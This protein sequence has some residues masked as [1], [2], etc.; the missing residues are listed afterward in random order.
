MTETLDLPL[1]FDPLFFDSLHTLILNAIKRTREL[2]STSGKEIE[3]EVRLGIPK[4]LDREHNRW[5][6]D[7]TIEK[8]RFNRLKSDLDVQ[9]TPKKAISTVVIRELK[10]TPQNRGINTN[11]RKITTLGSDVSTETTTVYQVKNKIESIDQLFLSSPISTPTPTSRNVY[12]LRFALSEEDSNTEGKDGSIEGKF[13]A[14][15]EK[16]TVTRQRERYT[17]SFPGYV[18]DLTIVDYKE[19]SIE[20]EF[21]KEF[22]L[23][24]ENSKLNDKRYIF[25]NR[26]LPPIKS[27]LKLI[28]PTLKDVWGLHDVT[29]RYFNL[30]QIGTNGARLSDVRPQN[31]EE[32]QV[33]DLLTGYSFSN[34]LNGTPYRVMISNFKH[35]KTD[36]CMVFLI[37]N[38]DIKFVGVDV[39][40]RTLRSSISRDSKFLIDFNNSLIDIELYP[41]KGEIQQLH[42]FDCPVFQGK[43]NTIESHDKRLSILKTSDKS[44]SLRFDEGFNLLL[45]SIGYSF[46]IKKFFYTGD[47]LKDLTDVVQYMYN[48]YGDDTEEVNDGI[49]QQPVGTYE[50]VIRGKQV[51]QKKS[52]YDRTYRI[53]KWKFPDTVSIDFV[54]GE[55]DIFTKNKYKNKAFPILGADRDKLI[56]FSPYFR[57]K[58]Y[59]PPSVF[60]VNDQD[61]NYDILESGQVVELGFDDLHNS[62]RLLRVRHDKTEPNAISPTAQSTFTQMESKFTLDKL[63]DLLVQAIER[64]SNITLPKKNTQQAPTSR[65]N[66]PQSNVTLPSPMPTTSNVKCLDSYR[67]L[68]NRIKTGLIKMYCEGKQIIDFGA[69]KGGDLSKIA[70]SDIKY[71]WAVEPNREYINGKDG[72]ID[73]LKKYK[74]NFQKKVE[75]ILTGAEDTKAITQAMMK[76]KDDSKVPES[77]AQVAFSFF[78]ASFFFRDQQTINSIIRSIVGSLQVGGKL[79]GTMMDGQRVYDALQA[80]G[81]TVTDPNKCYYIKQKFPLNIPLT[82]VGSEIGINLSDTPTVQNEQTEWLAPFEYLCSELLKENM[83]LVDTLYFDDPHISNLFPRPRES[84]PTTEDIYKTMSVGEKKLNRLYR[85]FVFERSKPIVSDAS[86]QRDVA[87]QKER[88]KNSLETMD[89]DKIGTGQFVQASLYSEPLY[90]VGVAGMG[91]CFFHAILFSLIS[92]KYS[93]MSSAERIQQAATLR[94]AIAKALSPEMLSILGNGAIEYSQYLPYLKRVLQNDMITQLTEEGGTP[95]ISMDQIN[96][97]MAQVEPL[98]TIQQQISHIISAFGNLGYSQHDIEDII[99]EAR[100]QLWKDYTAK[101]KNCNEWTTHDT[102]EYIMRKLQRNIFIIGDSTRLP[103]KFTDCA[104][105]NPSYPSIVILNLEGLTGKSAEHFEPIIDMI[106]DGDDIITTTNFKW[107][108]SLIKALYSYLCAQKD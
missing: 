48:C 86:K 55:P 98:S 5:Q 102:M 103:I 88:E 33:P 42:A 78:S 12:M 74:P 93:Q 77:Q 99:Q 4:K 30:L 89:V 79:I 60:I 3:L 84:D 1:I 82:D 101:L 40:A 17:Y 28:F 92:N 19:Y 13:R 61:P 72:F 85:Y 94:T 23:S 71:Y 58:Y 10:G 38:T 97:I 27:M 39:E 18:I 105:Y 31:I 46:E 45:K 67:L 9:T 57:G 66:I 50:A 83:T 21:S 73:R 59:N 104:L 62:F 14:A 56:V 80:E 6:F 87:L 90:R 20:L 11:I 2:S 7:S 26:F 75:V 53:Y 41:Y 108:S 49:I 36:I 69:G 51:I 95:T 63:R 25:S 47:P 70:N 64:S 54:L 106:E 37:S 65:A 107:D 91:S 96:E 29:L 100:L 43:S 81:G 16:T 24:I 44:T 8:E 68:H 22:I 34:K 15:D 35:I 32:S 76:S 52:Y